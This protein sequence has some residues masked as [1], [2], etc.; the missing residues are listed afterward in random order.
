VWRWFVQNQAPH[1]NWE[2]APG[3]ASGPG[4]PA[5]EGARSHPALAAR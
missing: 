4:D 5:G 1:T 2:I 3:G